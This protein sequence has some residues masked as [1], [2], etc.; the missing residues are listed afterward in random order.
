MNQLEYAAI[1]SGAGLRRIDDRIFVRVSG[2]DRIAFMQGMCSADVKKLTPGRLV[3]ALFLTERAHI[4]ADSFLYALEE[5]LML[6][7]DRRRWPFL[8][9]HLERFLVADDVELEELD[10]LALLDVEGPASTEPVMRIFGEHVQS[11]EPWHH[12]AH[13]DVRVANLPRYGVRAF[14]VL[15]EDTA[16]VR[17]AECMRELDPRICDLH[18]ETLE[19]LRIENGIAAVGTDT[20]E[21]TLALEAR[22]EEAIAFNKGC[23]L[24]QETVERASAHGSLKRRLCGLYLE[25]P[26]T[27]QPGAVVKLEEKEVGRLSSVARLP[28]S[29]AIGLAI[30]HHSAW[31]AGTIV[32]VSD[33]TSISRATVC[34][35]PFGTQYPPPATR[36]GS[37]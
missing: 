4:V 33:N 23:Y 16:L 1:H 36:V 15:G 14:T 11:L 27:P 7:L 24:G 21:R 32:S 25:G 26:E 2:D 28:L 31:P 9:Q 12:L 35:L 29:G 20:D 37:V 18:P 3:R 8:R 13:N 5:F 34:E 17:V 10:G 6:E 30:L 22:F 19:I